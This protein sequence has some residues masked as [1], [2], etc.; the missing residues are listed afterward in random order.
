MT[1][2]LFKPGG[3]QFPRWQVELR[4]GTFEEPGEI[5]TGLLGPVPQARQVQHQPGPTRTRGD[6]PAGLELADN[7]E[8]VEFFRE[9]FVGV[10][11][12]ATN[13]E[14]IGFVRFGD[15]GNGAG[16]HVDG[17]RAGRLPDAGF[18]GGFQ[19]H[20]VGGENLAM[21]NAEIGPVRFQFGML[22]E[23]LG[24]TPADVLAVVGAEVEDIGA[25]DDV[26]VIEMIL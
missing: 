14:K 23:R 3:L 18:G 26:A 19:H 25:D 16:F 2:D 8:I 1:G 11:G 12:D 9:A 7:K 13:S 4:D 22:G 5:L 20:F 17:I 15:S 21:D 6:D 10:V 24:G